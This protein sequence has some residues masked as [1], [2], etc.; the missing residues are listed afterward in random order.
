VPKRVKHNTGLVKLVEDFGSEHHC[1]DYLEHLRWRTGVACPRCGSVSVSRIYDRGQFDCNQCRFRFS[2]TSGT[3]F[4][5]SHLP[6]WKWYLTAYMM[7]ESKSGLSAGQIKRTLQVSYK[8]AWYL[9][10][11]IRASLA[12]ATPSLPHGGGVSL[13]SEGAQD[14]PLQGGT[15]HPAEGADGRSTAQPPTTE[16]PWNVRDRPTLRSHQKIRAKHVGAYRDEIEFKHKNRKNRHVFRDTI[17]RLLETPR[18][19]YNDLTGSP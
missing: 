13:A 5:D 11:R 6:L 12:E 7:I 8:T 10:H 1:R 14:L 17:L 15:V 18:L 16:T 9:C 4:H 3:I 19:T 2:V